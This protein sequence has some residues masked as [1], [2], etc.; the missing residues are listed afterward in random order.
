[1]ARIY[2][3]DLLGRFSGSLKGRKIRKENK[4]AVKRQKRITRRDFTYHDLRTTQNQF[5]AKQAKKYVDTNY[6]DLVGVPI[7][8]NKNKSAYP[9]Y[10]GKGY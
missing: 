3:R 2:K 9:I 8:K 6:A 10:R 4:R 7:G 1:M 5:T